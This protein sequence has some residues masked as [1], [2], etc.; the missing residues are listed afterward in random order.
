MKKA[1][2]K[3]KR[4]KIMW[5]TQAIPLATIRTDDG[6]GSDFV[7]RPDFEGKVGGIHEERV[8]EGLVEKMTVETRVEI[9]AIK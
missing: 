2:K 1:K 4:H 7:A 8:F 3:K 9:L 5:V 6:N